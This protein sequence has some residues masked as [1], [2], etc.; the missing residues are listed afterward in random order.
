MKKSLW[1]YSG[2]KRLLSLMLVAVMLF[3]NFQ[4]V[5]AD[6][7]QAKPQIKNI[8]YMIPDGGGM[9]PFYLADYVKQA[10][11]LT[12]KY[13]N[14]TPVETG[15]MYIKDYLVGSETTYSAN[16]DV[17]DSAASGTAL[18]SG[19]KTDN[20]MVGI[21]PGMIPRANI[22]EACQDLGK[23][24]GIVVTC[25][26]T[27][28]TPGAFSAHAEDRYETLII[29]EQV[30][31]QDI[32]VVFGNTLD[33]YRDKEWFTDES[34]Q[35]RGY[36]VIKTKQALN[37]VKAGDRLWGKLSSPSYD[38][39][40]AA[41]T[42]N[43]SELTAA[44]IKALDDG[45]ENGFFLMVEGSQVDGGG[46]A[47]NALLMVSEWLA[48]DEACK[49]A[50][51]YAKG[52]DDTIVMIQPDHD[53]G[54]IKLGDTYAK[55]SLASLVDEIQDGI[56]P[57][58]ITWEGGTRHTGRNGG[59]FM[60]IPDGVPYPQGIDKSKASLVASEF[61][62]DFRE[63]S[64]NR[65]DNTTLAPYIAGLIGADLDELT[66]ELFVDVTDRGRYNSSTEVFTFT[67]D[68]GVQVEVKRNTSQA[69][70]RGKSMSLDGQVAVYLNNRFYVPRMLLD[71]RNL[72]K[73][74]ISIRTDF[75]QK[76]VNV[77]GI[78]EDA[79]A[80]VILVVTEPKIDYDEGMAN[81]KLVF[82]D[83]LKSSNLGEYSIDFR[84]KDAQVGDY[85]YYTNTVGEGY[86][87]EYSFSFKNMAIEKNGVVV[88]KMSELSAGDSIDLV[89]SGYDTSY[90]GHA[91]IGQY[92]D[93]G[94]LIDVQ[95]IPV[96]GK[97]VEG[98]KFDQAIESIISATVLD[99][100]KAIK[101][102]YWS[103][104]LVPFTGVYSVE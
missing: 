35:S 21:T 12:G 26:W 62:A 74:S 47:N 3:A 52:R 10:G 17:T 9:A 22:L 76:T 67:N 99:D 60:Y 15:E 39:N 14:A 104:D 75:N 57:S 91:V 102:F 41:T 90:D 25:A 81:E 92:D 11:G 93:N 84:V 28:A 82:I 7:N 73:S 36:N 29:G 88:D 24:T 34:L 53:T 96:Q 66:E 89:L 38:I 5:F 43:L 80:T 64:V 63:C 50:I 33:D 46:H 6:N 55:S 19:Y 54:G 97:A 87:K 79:S 18:S 86:H 71:A 65:I 51:E 42:P 58:S 77:S 69:T 1:C 4:C 16:N 37:S 61:E 100:T 78:T 101:A 70:V 59:L 98:T 48:F 85:T 72:S 27:E 13:P 49:V 32:D 68:A 23:N 94:A 95:Y 20:A 83:Q 8:I 31:N 30:V 45:N 2:G 40:R 56:N 103:Y 44:A